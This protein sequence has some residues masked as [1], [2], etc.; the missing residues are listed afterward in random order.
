MTATFRPGTDAT[1][2][3]AP[4]DQKKNDF[5]RSEA[6]RDHTQ[7]DLAKR[8]SYSVRVRNGDRSELF[9]ISDP[10]PYLQIQSVPID[11]RVDPE[12][13]SYILLIQPIGI[14]AAAGQYSTAE[15]DEVTQATRG[16]DWRLDENQRPKCLGR[17]VEL[18]E[19]IC[20]KSAKASFTKNFQ[21][22][23]GEV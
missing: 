13:N 10:P 23:G 5:T 9:L 3:L 1:S 17:L 7:S 20:K 15:T 8:R 16:W 18:L 4:S 21:N 19:R 14:R 22:E 6:L 2:T 12:R 11:Q